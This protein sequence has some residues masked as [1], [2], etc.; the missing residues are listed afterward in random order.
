[1]AFY[2]PLHKF[3]DY[4]P[5]YALVVCSTSESA[6]VLYAL[7]AAQNS[8]SARGSLDLY[9]HPETKYD[10]KVEGESQYVVL[11]NT[12]V[13]SRYL[14]DQV[15][16]HS[17]SGPNHTSREHDAIFSS[18]VVKI[19]EPE[20]MDFIPQIHR[21]LESMINN[22]QSTRGFTFVLKIFFVGHTD[23]D[24]IEVYAE[25]PPIL[26]TV[27]DIHTT[28]S[29]TGA[30]YTMNSSVTT[31]AITAPRGVSFKTPTTIADAMRRLNHT[32]ETRSKSAQ[33]L[34]GVDA[35]VTR[36][37]V[38]IDPA[39]ESDRYTIDNVGHDVI[40]ENGELQ[41]TAG[42]QDNLIDIIE[43][44]FRMSY[45]VIDDSHAVTSVTQGE[46]AKTPEKEPDLTA[47]YIPL[48]FHAVHTTNSGEILHVIYVARHRVQLGTNELSQE[49]EK[50]KA[51][52]II[53][54]K[55][56]P[57]RI[58]PNDYFSSGKG[59]NSNNQIVYDYIHT[60]KNIDILQFQMN[61]SIT[62][63]SV[64]NL[65]LFTR[66][67]SSNVEAMNQVN[68]YSRHGS[69]D[70]VGTTNN[71]VVATNS[72]NSQL[73]CANATDCA[74]VTTEITRGAMDPVSFYA[75]RIL[76]APQI[77][78]NM[79][80]EVFIEIAGNPQY[81]Y[82]KKPSGMFVSPNGPGGMTAASGVEIRDRLAE[83][84]DPSNPLTGS[85]TNSPIVR[86]NVRVPKP[87]NLQ[88]ITLTGEN[89]H[90]ENSFATDYWAGGEYFINT[91]EH[92]F[93]SGGFTQKLALMRTG[94]STLTPM[95]NTTSTPVTPPSTSQAVTKAAG[96]V[97]GNYESAGGAIGQ[98]VKVDPATGF[99]AIIV[100]YRNG[101]KKD[102]IYKP[103]PKLAD[104][105][106]KTSKVYGVPPRLV[107][108]LIQQESRYS[109]HIDAGIAAPD[110]DRAH[111]YGQFM[112]RTAK[113]FKLNRYDPVEN[114]TGI[115]AHLAENLKATHGDVAEALRYY[116]GGPNWNRPGRAP[117]R[118]KE[119]REYPVKI[120]ADAGVASTIPVPT[121][122]HSNP[123]HTIANLYKAG[124]L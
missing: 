31:A 56:E 40:D 93:D 78:T 34:A 22:D 1:M 26:M 38:V 42:P 76:L 53:S 94:N 48:P 29:F 50:G 87:S 30:H 124:K 81:L 37:Y 59:R 70:P 27:S 4:T 10:V 92:T 77:Y 72:L 103:N 120:M 58:D 47:R 35:A 45:Q 89:T 51:A 112:D 5:H 66:T 80:P 73:R 25:T 6:D 41:Y 44:I 46:K 12:L 57:D 96:G 97:V 74:S 113:G 36:Y 68:E 110:G 33:V 2:N 95:T 108:A 11:I 24:V 102:P 23:G 109:A 117:A 64:A 54:S 79:Q 114:V 19:I 91:I 39:Y 13:D 52:D 69:S 84:V 55:L 63:Q 98:E 15:T 18:A 3:R 99:G 83:S 43:S 118:L 90:L 17:T 61:A 101:N 20:T 16:L 60:G 82:I 105:I 49:I 106:D 119:T 9:N 8:I 121:D 123:I 88:G 115:A 100:G 111:G 75:S 28:L 107:G 122:W 65:R 85:I 104:L 62:A 86:I 32:L 14:I 71:S 7:D 116:N 67:P 21:A